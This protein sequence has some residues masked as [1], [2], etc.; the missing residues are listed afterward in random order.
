MVE[1]A[2]LTTL[3]DEIAAERSLRCVVCGPIAD[4]RVY[5]AEQYG[6]VQALIVKLDASQTLSY[7]VTGYD[8]RR[9]VRSLARQIRGELDD[10]FPISW[11]S[12]QYR[13]CGP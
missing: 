3:F 7:T 5:V 12:T 6:D 2:V 8:R 10:R 9:G 11:S 1:A 4:G 13:T